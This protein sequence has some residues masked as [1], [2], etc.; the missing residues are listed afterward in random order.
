MPK[1]ADPALEASSS[2][3]RGGADGLPASR[4]RE[5]QNIEVTSTGIFDTEATV[6]S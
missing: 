3:R 4:R 6:I 2:P 1:P 5:R